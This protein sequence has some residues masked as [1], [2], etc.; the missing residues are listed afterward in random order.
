M[1]VLF[2]LIGTVL[3]SDRTDGVLTPSKGKPINVCYFSS[4]AQYRVGAA[5]S[6]SHI[7]PNLCTHINYAFAFVTPDGHGLRTYQH[8]DEAMYAQIMAIRDTK[9]PNLK[10]SVF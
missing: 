5:Y 3:G 7:D 4:W 2:L 1:W 9:N 8:N 10:G 6:T